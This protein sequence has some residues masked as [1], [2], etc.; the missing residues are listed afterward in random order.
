[1]DF[2][3]STAQ[4]S[5]LLTINIEAAKELKAENDSLRS[6]IS[7]KDAAFA[8]RLDALEARGR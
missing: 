8:A 7:A 4:P 3:L 2:K 1:M 5:L 6:E